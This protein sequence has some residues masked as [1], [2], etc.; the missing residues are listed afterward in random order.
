MPL[1]RSKYDMVAPVGND[2]S[3]LIAN[4][5]TGTAHLLSAAEMETWRASSDDP[6]FGPEEEAQFRRRYLEFL[7][8]RDTDE[9]QLFYVPGYACNFD[10]DYCYQAD[11]LQGGGGDQR[12]VIDALFDYVEHAFAGRRRYFTLFGGEPL[13]PGASARDAVTFFLAGATRRHTTTAV[14]TNGYFVEEYLDV[15]QDSF[16]R[17][18]QVTLDGTEDLHN[19]RRPRKDGGPTFEKIVRGVDQLL[20]ARIPVNLRMVVDRDNLDN[21]PDLARFAIDRGWTADPLF[22]TQLGRNYEL[23]ACQHRATAILSRLELARELADIIAAHPHVM[24]FHAPSFHFVRT[25][26]RTGELPDPVFD[27]CPGCKTEWAFD[28]IGRAHV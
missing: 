19:R 12:P 22:K 2:G 11:Y 5:L 13:L 24:A 26:A 17:E 1:R 8:A 20:A 27:S 3:C 4:A 21:L 7:D 9:V 6:S 14:V 18:V 25:L 16:I 28:Q 23:H 15:L 10:C